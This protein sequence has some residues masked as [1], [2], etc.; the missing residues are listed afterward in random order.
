M[1]YALYAFLVTLALFVGTLLALEAGRWT[2]LRQIATGS[3]HLA[4][5]G[6]DAAWSELARYA[7]LQNEIWRKAVAG[8]QQGD[9]TSAAMLLLPAVNAMIDITTTRTMAT[10]MHPP[11]AVFVLLF[12]LATI[13]ALIA[14]HGMAAA[15][16]R[17]WLH[18][19]GFAAAV[20]R[21][22]YIILDMEHP[23][24]GLIQVSSFDQSLRDLRQSMQ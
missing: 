13:S 18:M 10:H 20:A 22:C 15:P 1:N 23:R 24:F 9:N 11:F 8:C 7:D 17:S 16:A 4:G 12:A 2:G 14:G 3:G 19:N 5:T 6:I 21:T